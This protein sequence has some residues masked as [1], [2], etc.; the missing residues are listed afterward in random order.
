MLDYFTL[1]I[2]TKRS[3]NCNRLNFIAS[4][5]FHSIAKYYLALLLLMSL[6]FCHDI[7][8]SLD[9]PHIQCSTFGLCIVFW[10]WQ[11]FGFLIY[12]YLCLMCLSSDDSLALFFEHYTIDLIFFYFG[13][14]ANYAPVYSS[15]LSLFSGFCLPNKHPHT[16]SRRGS[17]NNSY[18]SATSTRSNRSGN[19]NQSNK[20]GHHHLDGKCRVPTTVMETTNSIEPIMSDANHESVTLALTTNSN[21]SPLSTSPNM[22]DL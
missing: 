14:E 16:G 1:D 18:T 7:P 8:L 12:L 17:R 20:S 10:Q 2:H 21:P 6:I 3:M 4:F 5:S 22:V 9:W 15:I 11:S 19:A 13:N